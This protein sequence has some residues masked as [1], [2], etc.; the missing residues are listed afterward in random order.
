[1]ILCAYFCILK[2]FLWIFGPNLTYEIIAM[3]WLFATDLHVSRVSMVQHL[4]INISK[5]QKSDLKFISN[6]KSRFCILSDFL[7]GRRIIR[8]A[9]SSDPSSDLPTGWVRL[10]IPRLST[11]FSQ[12]PYRA[13]PFSLAL[14]TRLEIFSNR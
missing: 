8:G 14:F 3:Y 7:S 9:G 6:P 2:D 1:M 5:S 11:S 10:Y 4:W 12:Q 13:L